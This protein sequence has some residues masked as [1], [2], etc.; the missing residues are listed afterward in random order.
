M[1]TLFRKKNSENKIKIWAFWSWF[2]KKKD[3]RPTAFSDFAEKS[4]FKIEE[5]K[6]ILLYAQK[7]CPFY[8]ANCYIN[9]DN[10]CLALECML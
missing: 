4:E 1:T 9:I 6:H 2:K 8:E 7:V 5:E 10:Y 3:N